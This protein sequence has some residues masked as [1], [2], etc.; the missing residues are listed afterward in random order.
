MKVEQGGTQMWCPKCKAI[1][2]CAAVSLTH[3]GHE[4]G[5]RWHRTDH[6]DINWFRRGRECQTCRHEF[7][8]TEMKRE[9]S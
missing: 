1:R 6:P 3:L 8:T 9:F 5:Q 7:V 4:S 2:V